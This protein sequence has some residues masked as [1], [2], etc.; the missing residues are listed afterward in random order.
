MLPFNGQSVSSS[1]AF[2]K[3]R[4]LSGRSAGSGDHF[5]TSN[6]LLVPRVEN[7]ESTASP[8]DVD[9]STRP[10]RQSWHVEFASAVG[11]KVV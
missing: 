9:N 3:G 5:M 4:G 10:L 1:Q 7:S 11:S 8:S 6:L 2:L